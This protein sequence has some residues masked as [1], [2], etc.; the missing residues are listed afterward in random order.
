MQKTLEVLNELE[1]EG[2]LTRYAIGGAIGAMFYAE[3]ASTFDLDIFCLIPNSGLLID[4][5]PLY[6]SLEDKGYLPN[7][8]EQI[9]I[10]GIPVQFIVT[11][12]GLEEEA[13][14][15]AVETEF[16]E[17]K[18]RVFT[19]EHLL[20]IMVKTGRPKDIA[21]IETCL[22]TTQPDRAILEEILLRYNLLEKW[23]RITS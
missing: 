4:M 13:L 22:E 19:Y 6:K 7:K 2:V 23:K 16:S 20:A 8:E 10:E 12:P 21:R 1:R 11:P 15:M 18:S 5:G 3:P 17:V 9:V 14:E